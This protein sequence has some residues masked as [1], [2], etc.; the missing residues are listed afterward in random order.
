MLTDIHIWLTFIQVID[1]QLV[2]HLSR[3]WD[4][5]KRRFVSLCG[6]GKVVFERLKMCDSNREIWQNKRNQIRRE[7][8]RIDTN[9]A[10]EFMRDYWKATQI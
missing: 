2:M 1:I 3:A 4:S 7:S 5:I 10:R 8:M 9:N 6:L